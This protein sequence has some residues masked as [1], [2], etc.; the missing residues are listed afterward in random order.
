[1]ATISLHQPIADQTSRRYPGIPSTSDGSSAVIWVESHISQAAVAYPITPSTPITSACVNRPAEGVA[2]QRARPAIARCSR[3]NAH[4]PWRSTS[5]RS[6]CTNVKALAWASQFAEVA[7]AQ[8]GKPRVSGGS[9]CKIKDILKAL[10]MALLLCPAYGQKPDLSDWG[11]LN[12]LEVGQRVEIIEMNLKRT[13]GKWMAFSADA[14]SLKIE[15]AEVSIP[16]LGVFRISSL[17]KSKRLRNVLLGVAIGGVAGLAA[18]A[19]LDSSFSEN[20]E[21]IGKMIFTP[22]GVGAGAG[23]GAAMARFETIY[24]AQD[25]SR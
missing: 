10:F 12:R 2:G 7:A 19:A 21:H 25:V 14:L 1:M 9:R 15:N 5:A 11:N 4:P 8:P 18:G 22:I 23:L 6:S 16:R 3:H 17:E 20:D 24:R 13:R